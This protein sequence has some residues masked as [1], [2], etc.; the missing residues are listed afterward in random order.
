MAARRD[1]Q[2]L[3]LLAW[4]PPKLVVAIAPEMIKAPTFRDRLARAVAIVLTESDIPR[5][6][7][8][9]RMS[10]FLGEDISLNMLN[11]YAS[12]ARTDQTIPAVRLAALTQA[13]G[14]VRALQL[15]LDPIDYAAV[16]K[17]YVAAIEDAMF[18]DHI[19]EVQNLQAL[20]RRKWK[21]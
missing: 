21:S 4:E 19:K 20:A 17:R 2:T 8:A 10:E 9:K 12:Q 16:E 7:I 6:T 15:L 13:T 1:V 14:D 11:A 5:A 18:S 3:D